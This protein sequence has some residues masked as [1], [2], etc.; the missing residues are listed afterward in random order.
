MQAKILLAIFSISIFIA[1][2]AGCS[3]SS[4]P[5]QSAGSQ[6]VL[7]NAD[8]KR[9]ELT[10]NAQFAAELATE[11]RLVE[12]GRD[13]T[14]VFT[15]RNK[16]GQV[17]MDLKVVHEK[18]IHLLI[19]SEDLAEFDHVHPERQSDGSFKIVHKFAN[20]GVYKLYA[21]F[22][23]QNSPQIVNLFDVTVGGPA[24]PKAPL[25]ADT[26]LTKTVDGL[27]FTLKA[28][29]PIKAS[30]GVMLDFF[31]S[32]PSGAAV[33]DLQ[34]YLGAMA[35]FVVISEDTNRFLHVH[36]SEGETTKTEA[37][38]G[39][40]PAMKDHGNM[41]MDDKPEKAG[42]AE[43][44]VQAH[45]EFPSAGLYKLWGQFQR[46]GKVYTVSFVLD[47]AAGE[48]NA[49]S[50][51]GV[52]AGAIKIDVTSNGFEPSQ[53]SVARGQTVKLAF[54]RK[55]DGNCGS[56]VVFTKLNVKKDLPA[57]KTT[58]VE[59]TPTEAGDLAFTCGMDMLKGKLVVQ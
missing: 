3:Q 57:G 47:I 25:V 18:L 19:V 20:G 52:P 15:V 29:R 11:P 9:K 32:D 21:D 39:G 10:E 56:E 22:T 6:T 37:S 27:T 35:H 41:Q 1:S 38:E 2:L 13:A 49:A 4:A 30:R 31:V 28:E 34:P 24:R 7:A 12:A 51:D 16:Q 50:A 45:T 36:A 17:A 23:P 40:Q 55:D 53:V 5:E 59:I 26:D 8:I 43:P 14:L 54:N 44:T 42:S 46:A 48:T 33:T 58:V